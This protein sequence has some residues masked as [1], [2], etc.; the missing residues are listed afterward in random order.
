MV[1]NGRGGVS[2]RSGEVSGVP[3]DSHSALVILPGACRKV[4]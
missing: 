3:L 2:D 4:L 1:A